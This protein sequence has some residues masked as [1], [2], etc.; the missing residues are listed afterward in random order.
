MYK[1]YLQIDDLKLPGTL[2]MYVIKRTQEELHE[3]NK[4]LKVHEIFEGIAQMDFHCIAA[5]ILQSVLRVSGLDEEEFIKIYLK[6][7]SDDKIAQKL[8]NES[9]YLNELLK[10]CMFKSKEQKE[11]DEFEEIPNF[12]EDKSKDW[13]FPY[14]E[15]F[16]TTKLKRNDFWSIT[17]KHYFEQIEIYERVNGS[18]KE[19]EE[20]EYL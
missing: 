13:D 15:F 14:M 16:W 20:T 12:T 18:N 6:E 7:R 1:A 11:D 2:D 19:K 5:L 3:C 10:K 4:L 8:L 17:P 9:K